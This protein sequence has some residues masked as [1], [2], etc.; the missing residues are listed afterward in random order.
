MMARIGPEYRL[1]CDFSVGA[2]RYRKGVQIETVREA[3]QRWYNA[4]CTISTEP[5]RP[6]DSDPFNA[7]WNAC[8]EHLR[9]AGKT[10]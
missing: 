8:L 1:P 5:M 7:G 2:I 10:K 9:R 4:A 3:A 6:D